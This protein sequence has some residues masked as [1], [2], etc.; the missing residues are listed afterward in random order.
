MP[1]Y[2]H[3]HSPNTHF[4]EQLDTYQCSHTQNNRRCKNRV[5]IGLSMCWI[6]TR[7]NLHI[8]VTNSKIHNAGVGLFAFDNKQADNAIIFR[9]GDK[10]CDYNGE[11][12]DEAELHRRYG[13]KTAPYAIQINTDGRYEDGATHRGIGTL[14]NSPTGTTHR[15]NCRFSVGKDRKAH[16]VATRNIKNGEEL[17]ISYGRAYRFNEQGV[18][19]TTNNK[20]NNI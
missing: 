6:H 4:D 14:L 15:P 2:F 10:I 11:I 9:K 17:Y 1:T 12:I 7:F 19:S 3:F 8:K 13:D 16:I 5:C 20:K 18:Q